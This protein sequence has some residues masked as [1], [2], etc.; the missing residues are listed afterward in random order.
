LSTSARVVVAG[1]GFAGLHCAQSLNEAGL[2]VLVLEARE[3]VGGRVWSEAPFGEE[4]GVIERGAEFVLPGYER[5][6]SLLA[7]HGLALAPMG[8]SYGA[9][10][11]RGGRPTTLVAMRRVAEEAGRGAARADNEASAA[12]VLAGVGEE[13]DDPAALAAFRSRFETSAA[14]DAR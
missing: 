12:D 7:A 10:E 2:E 9:R 8:M 6:T 3:R 13:L 1:A 14:A 4:G 11:P 5:L